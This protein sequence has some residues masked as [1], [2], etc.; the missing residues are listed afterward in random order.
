MTWP[1]VKI[2]FELLE[3]EGYRVLTAP[4]GRIGLSLAREQKPDIILCDIMMPEV[5]GYTVFSE[6]KQDIKTTSIPFIFLT[7]SVEKKEVEKAFG[8][9]VQGYIR[10]PFDTE[11]LFNAISGCLQK[12]SD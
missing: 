10:K 2:R 8:M 5:D 4:N 12:K 3:L 7:A 9:G 6:L 11:E 1:Y